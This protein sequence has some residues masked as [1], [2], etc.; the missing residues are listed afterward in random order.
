MISD[1]PPMFSLGLVVATPG[2]IGVLKASRQHASE[3]LDR[4]AHGDWGEVSRDDR[5]LNDEALR[6]GARL[7]S[8]YHTSSGEQLWV[9]TEA[10]RSAT[11]LLLP[12]EY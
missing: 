3:F 7:V 5:A 9:I 11:T 2:A 8:S 6:T 10:D 4:H 1:C 12:S